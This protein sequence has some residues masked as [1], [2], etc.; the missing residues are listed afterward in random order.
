MKRET[1]RRLE[2]LET[3]QPAVG[4]VSHII[5]EAEGKGSGFT[6]ERQSDGTWKHTTHLPEAPTQPNAQEGT[7]HE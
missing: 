5:V 3:Q 6:M 7:H 2:R 1:E 4:D